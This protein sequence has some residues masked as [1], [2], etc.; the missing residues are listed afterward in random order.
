V[1]KLKDLG[2]YGQSV[3]LDSIGRGLIRNGE[4][5]RL[6]QEDGVSGVT[7]N[8]S[9]FEKAIGGGG[10]EYAD[11]IRELAPTSPSAE[12]LYEEL[13]VRDIQDAAD[14]LRPVYD[15]TDGR[16]GFVSLEVSPELARDGD[17][18][19]AAARRLWKTVGRENAMIKVPAT[20][21]GIGTLEALFA[22]GINVNVTLL[23]SVDAYE[24]VARAYLAGLARR[25][26]RGEPTGRVAS[27]ASFFVSRVDSAVDAELEAK[28]ATAVPAAAEGLRSLLGRTAIANA[29]LAY[30]RFE[31]IFS[32]PEW[33]ALEEKGGRRQRVLWASTG[34]KNPAYRDVVY[35]EEMIGP[36][37]VS[38]MPPA[39]LDAFRDHGRAR[40][41]LTAGVEEARASLDQ[42]NRAG[43]SLPDVTDRL[44]EEGLAL[45]LAAYRKLLR[46]VE[47]ARRSK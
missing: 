11:A 9:I 23:F 38:T 6:V 3:W 45:F 31:E 39:T 14:V 22:E 29:K 19:L 21:E 13:A 17:G 46:T 18:T 10:G 43:F 20:P 32:G 33:K 41:S 28:I 15:A 24:R 7:S 37:T 26:G 35:V 27:V 34:T 8:P 36:D 12:A 16:D 30:A 42:L 4:L 40:P 25:A 5:A 2:T 47:D 44:L 1:S